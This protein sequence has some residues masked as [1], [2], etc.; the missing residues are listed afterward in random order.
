MK[1]NPNNELHVP[2]IIDGEWY[3]E[4]KT[5]I[6]VLRITENGVSGWKI[7][8][9]VFHSNKLDEDAYFSVNIDALSRDNVLCP[10]CLGSGMV[11]PRYLMDMV[12]LQCDVCKGT[13]KVNEIVYWD[14]RL[15][16]EVASHRGV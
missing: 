10:V 7:P 14:K 5:Q 4:T 2:Y 15:G 13:G 3:I 6:F 8:C 1:L 9:W 11:H 16:L 12:D